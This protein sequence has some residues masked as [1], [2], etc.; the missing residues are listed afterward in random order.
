MR[1]AFQ[2][3]SIKPAGKSHFGDL[4]INQDNIKWDLKAWAVNWIH[5]AF[6]WV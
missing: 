2:D 6:N 3:F 5:V 1:N 4:C